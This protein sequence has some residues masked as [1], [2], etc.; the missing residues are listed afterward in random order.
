MV[1]AWNEKRSIAGR[2]RG[3]V[4]ALDFGALD[5]LI[6]PR[7]APNEHTEPVRCRWHRSRATV[8]LGRDM[9]GD[10]RRM[11]RITPAERSVHPNARVAAASTSRDASCSSTPTETFRLPST[12]FPFSFP[13]L[14]RL[15]FPIW[16]CSFSA[17]FLLFFFRFFIL[18]GTER[19]REWS[20]DTKKKSSKKRL[21]FD[22]IISRECKV[23]VKLVTIPKSELFFIYDVI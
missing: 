21:G 1:D 8:V 6:P 3:G 17:L 10:T 22:Y 9:I 14:F 2:K 11:K 16:L 13:F 15:N 7:P 18:A 23:R 5:D 4:A 19:F 20:T 12:N